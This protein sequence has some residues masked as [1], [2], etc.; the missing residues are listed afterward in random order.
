MPF[1]DDLNRF[2]ALS[3]RLTGFDGVA[4]E[5]T[6]LTEAYRAV[7]VEELGAKRYA[8]LLRELRGPDDA[9]DG[10]L[11][12]AARAVTYLWYTGSWPGPPPIVVSPRAYAEALVWKAAGLKAPATD[13]GGYGSWGEAHDGSGS[14][15][16][17]GGSGR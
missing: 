8:R 9:V 17:I 16:G 1:A 14:G 7:A 15:N 3:A 5:A 2:A 4:L 6:G 12:E 10:E 11:R 13:P